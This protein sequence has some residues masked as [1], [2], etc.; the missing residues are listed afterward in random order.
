MS[1]K[2]LKLEKETNMWKSRW[3][4]SQTALLEMATDKQTRDIEIANINKKCSLLQEL[5]K[6]FQQERATLLAQLKES[7][8]K[9]NSNEE[10]CLEDNQKIIESI[11]NT[12]ANPVLNGSAHSEETNSENTKDIKTESAVTVTKTNAD[13]VVREE[14][15]F[16]LDT[17][18]NF[19]NESEEKNNIE[20]VNRNNEQTVVE[21]A[22][23]K[24]NECSLLF[25]ETNKTTQENLLDSKEDKVP[26]VPTGVIKVD[27]TETLDCNQL[28]KPNETVVKDSNSVIL[29]TCN[30]AES[31]NNSQV[32]EEQAKLE[33]L[34]ISD[35]KVTPTQENQTV[36][37][38]SAPSDNV[39]LDPSKK[40]KVI[41][42]LLKIQNITNDFIKYINNKLEYSIVENIG[43]NE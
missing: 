43:H 3:E 2:I 38:N 6:A 27:K 20:T 32:D 22:C 18:V 30:V 42:Y 39:C 35:I 34:V 5:C 4:K 13:E 29:N 28:I 25:D 21:S 36:N 17:K 24:T 12:S 37:S 1:K 14:S 40:N 9:L 10:I 33:K 23:K 7:S 8:S 16:V 15:K 26:Q 31:I 19:S 41:I 11:E